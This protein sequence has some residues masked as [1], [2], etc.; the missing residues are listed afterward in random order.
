MGAAAAAVGPLQ[1][2]EGLQ[3]MLPQQSRSRTKTRT[4]CCVACCL[5]QT[6]VRWAAVPAT[7]VALL[8]GPHQQWALP[9]HLLVRVWVVFL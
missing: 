6:V 3:H 1:H 4:L 7:A 5:Y 9:C 2:Q 8:L